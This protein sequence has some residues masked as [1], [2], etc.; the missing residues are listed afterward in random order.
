MQAQGITADYRSDVKEDNL[1]TE[2]L[3]C[4]QK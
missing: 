2:Y 4:L 3:R 1:S